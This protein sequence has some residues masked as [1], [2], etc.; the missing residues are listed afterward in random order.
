MPISPI[1]VVVAKPTKH[2]KKISK[3]RFFHLTATKVNKHNR[4]KNDVEGR[5]LFVEL[6]QS[7]PQKYSPSSP[8]PWD[9]TNLQGVKCI[10]FSP[11][12]RLIL[13]GLACLSRPAP[14]IEAR[15]KLSEGGQCF[16]DVSSWLLGLPCTNASCKICRLG[17]STPEML[18]SSKKYLFKW[19]VNSTK[20]LLTVVSV[21][22]PTSPKGVVQHFRETEDLAL[23]ER[24]TSTGVSPFIAPGGLTTVVWCWPT[25]LKTKTGRPFTPVN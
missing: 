11:W 12:L 2:D 5:V 14:Q 20:T 23:R 10:T 3:W 15:Y 16:C 17:R 4:M 21:M 8:V 6:H 1:L 13:P 22:L 18:F 9:G 19:F 7:A 25:K 24:M